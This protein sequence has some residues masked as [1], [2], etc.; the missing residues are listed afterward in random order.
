MDN[1]KD[2]NYFIERIAK[3]LKFI[4]LHMI[5]VDQEKL[6]SD[7]V[8]LD[9]MMFRIIQISENSMKLSDTY[10]LLHPQIPW[11]AVYGFRNRVVHDYGNVD[12]NIVYSA[13]TESIP[14]LLEAIS[15]IDHY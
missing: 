3:D 11:K 5:N 10:K 13:L 14:A 6:E 2:D 4:V 7:E 9:S 8:L 1:K 15:N 12:L